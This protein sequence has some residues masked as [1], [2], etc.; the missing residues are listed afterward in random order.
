MAKI[1][2]VRPLS[3]PKRNAR[4]RMD[5]LALLASLDPGSAKLVFFDPQYRGILD[6]QRYGNE[7][8]RQARRSALPQMTDA[9]IE[10]FVGAIVRALRPSGHLVV[11]ADKF[12]VASGRHLL[13]WDRHAAALSLVD[14]IVWNKIAP[15]MGRRSRCYYEEAL[16]FQK[17]PRR[18]KGVWLDRGI[19]DCWPEAADRSLHPHAKPVQLIY[20]LIRCVTRT[21]DLVV[22][23]CAGGYGVLAA[24]Q[25][26]GREFVGGDLI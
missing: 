9:D 4:N 22:D 13:W 5:G 11:W 8:A 19:M 7:G 12:T 25:Q 24:C 23:P 6:K 17:E 10:R 2:R 26:T 18:A 15:G 21:G 20:R 3:L 16:V 1:K 14:K